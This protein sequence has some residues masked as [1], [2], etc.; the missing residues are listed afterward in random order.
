MSIALQSRAE[1]SST[2]DHLLFA[3]AVRSADQRSAAAAAMA[4]GINPPQGMNAQ[5]IRLIREI[6]AKRREFFPGGLFSDR[7]WEILLTLYASHLEQQR[8]S[9]TRLTAEAGIP[10]TTVLRWMSSLE[11]ADLIVRTGDITDNRR[12]FVRLSQ[13]GVLTMNSYFT[14]C[15]AAIAF[16]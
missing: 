15:G 14:A 1:S 6:R 9:I 16:A 3:Q 8:L 5:R 2:H 13:K 10:A 7:G 4:M 12:V 11:V